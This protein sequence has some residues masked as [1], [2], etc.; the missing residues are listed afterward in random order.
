MRRKNDTRQMEIKR[1]LRLHETRKNAIRARLREFARVPPQDYFYELVYCLLTPQSSAERAE[2]VVAA[3]REQHFAELGGDPEPI[4]RMPAHYIR[5]HRTK[6]RHL[7]RAREEFSEISAELKNGSPAPDLR[8][9]LTRHVMGLGYK[10]AT[11]FLRNIG[12]NGGLAILDRHILRNLKRFG[13]I[14][15]VPPA[16]SRKRYLK[17]EQSFQKFAGRIGIPLDELDL[18]FWSMETG[19]IRK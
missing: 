19:E 1:L 10:E 15:T 17:L 6:A 12:R 16:L 14:R 8:E 9:W 7:V 18:L 5:F 13:V 4:L 3:L 2:M 11:H